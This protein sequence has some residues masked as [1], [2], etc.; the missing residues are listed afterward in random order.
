MGRH[1]KKLRVQGAQTYSGSHASYY[2]GAETLVIKL[3]F[4]PGNGNRRLTNNIDL[5]L[6]F[7]VSDSTAKP[8]IKSL[9]VQLRIC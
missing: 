5:N 8:I 6:L 3:L 4:S 2:P 7:P 1:S 9:V